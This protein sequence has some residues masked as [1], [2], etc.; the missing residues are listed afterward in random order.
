MVP[1]CKPLHRGHDCVPSSAFGA[2]GTERTVPE[3]AAGK[4]GSRG[5]FDHHVTDE[6]NRVTQ[7]SPAL[8][9]TG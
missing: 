7:E 1:A 9:D 3:E 8:G 2:R 5:A 6:L 4:E